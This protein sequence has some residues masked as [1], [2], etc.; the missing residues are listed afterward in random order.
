MSASRLHEHTN[1]QLSAQISAPDASTSRSL[2]VLTALVRSYQA[3]RAGR[4]TG[5][6]Y[7]PSCSEYALE[8]L[9]T[10]GSAQGSLLAVRRIAR[11]GPWG[12]HGFDPVPER[13]TP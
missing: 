13:S 11:C 8:A 12:G 6:R 5:C 4:P 1:S 3:A 10:H 9:N 2:R 7:L